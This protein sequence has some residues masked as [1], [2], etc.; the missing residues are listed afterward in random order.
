MKKF[1]YSLLLI[2]VSLFSY[3]QQAYRFE[4]SGHWNDTNLASQITPFSNE[5]Q[6]WSD[7]IGW[8]DS[9][10][11]KEFVIMGS[12]DSIYFFDVSNPSSIK[13]CDVRWGRN[14]VINRDFEVY[15]HYV[16]CVSD[17]GP[18]GALQIF[19]LQYLPDSVHLVREDSAISSNTHSIFIDSNSKRLYLNITKPYGPGPKIGM[20]IVSLENPEQPI[21]IGQLTDSA[22]VCDRVHEAYYRNDTA[23][24]S[25]EYNGLQIFDVRNPQQSK[26]IG[27]ISPPYPFNG[28][29]HTG[30]LNDEGSMLVF[31]DELPYGLPIKLYDVSNKKAPDY[32]TSFN[33]HAG[34]TPHNVIWIGNKLWTSAYEDG[35][36]L[37]DMSNPENPVIQGFY[38]TY[39]QNQEG[40]YQGLTGCW[41][42]YP[43]FA[44]GYIAASDMHNG[45]FLLKYNQK[46]G[47]TEKGRSILKVTTYPNPTHHSLNLQI[48]SN[49]KETALVKIV[50]VNGQTVLQKQID[51]LD[52]ENDIKL[53]EVSEVEKGM[54]FV[55]IISE[56]G[57]SKHLPIVKY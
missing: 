5:R 33:S 42:V 50:S 35:M 27:G 7:L 46:V 24:C 25:C 53:E 18:G 15:S 19:D 39:P 21:L 20:Q 8:T 26:H 43:F 2:V 4:L 37:W 30:W 41:G 34:A 29:N 28:Y 56:S 32:K 51:L 49:Q 55:S 40:V 36:V 10:T 54:Y 44:S 47:L 45:L 11:G 14:R 12:I 22:K 17:N 23:Y 16:Y 3:A 38:D 52:G 1:S 13:K 48:V 57:L 31:T 9:S 6:I